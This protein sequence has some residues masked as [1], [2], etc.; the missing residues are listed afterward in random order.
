[1]K[2]TFK[3]LLASILAMVAISVQAAPGGIGEAPVILD[4]ANLPVKVL[5]NGISNAACTNVIDVS[6]YTS[7]ALGMY[8]K[9]PTDV[10]S[11]VVATV[12]KSIDGT[13]WDAFDTFTIAAN[14]TT[15]VGGTT[16]WSIGAYPKLRVT[17]S[18]T[19]LYANGITNLVV[20]WQGK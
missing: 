18:T 5:T 9:A 8:F 1:M 4:S 6:R 2:R 12:E 20:K 11:N 16:N 19:A 13:K 17:M 14:G 15:Q 10:T 3:L 7:F